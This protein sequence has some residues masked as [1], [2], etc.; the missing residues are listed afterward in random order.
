MEA[1]PSLDDAGSDGSGVGSP[2]AS[3][4]RCDVGRAGA[5]SGEMGWSVGAGTED[6]ATAVGIAP[7]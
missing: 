5:A 4:E 1:P 7:G 3:V 2:S 6:G